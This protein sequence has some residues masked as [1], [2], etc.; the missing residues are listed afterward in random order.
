MVGRARSA[1]V[2]TTKREHLVRRARSASVA[3]TKRKQQFYKN[4][5][6]ENRRFPGDDVPQ[7]KKIFGSLGGDP[8]KER[9]ACEAAEESNKAVQLMLGRGPAFSADHHGRPSLV[10][11]NDDLNSRLPLPGLRAACNLSTRNLTRLITKLEPEQNKPI[12]DFVN[13]FKQTSF[14]ATHFTS[15]EGGSASISEGNLNLRSREGLTFMNK[16]PRES[17]HNSPPIVRSRFRNDR[18]VFFSMEPSQGGSYKQN[19]RFGTTKFTVTAGTQDSLNASFAYSMIS[20]VDQGPSYIRQPTL[21]RIATFMGQEPKKGALDQG[22]IDVNHEDYLFST[23]D[24][25]E[26]IGLT[27]ARFI[28]E[29]HNDKEFVAKAIGTT[30]PERINEL[31]RMYLDPQILVPRM[32]H[33]PSGYFH[34]T[35]NGKPSNLPSSKGHKEYEGITPNIDCSPSFSHAPN[36]NGCFTALGHLAPPLLCLSDSEESKEKEEKENTILDMYT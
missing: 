7:L 29:E 31:I 26:A 22:D 25:G 3:T 18:H 8:W 1:S 5:P 16:L 35:R 30:D 10:K 21:K 13:I 28:M 12:A 19:S 2:T 15:P 6:L 32:L 36:R 23:L 34:T 4:H 14:N 24:M 17:R 20:L 33:A 11:V 27:L 9:F